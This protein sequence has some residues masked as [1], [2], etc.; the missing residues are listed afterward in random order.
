[1]AFLDIQ[2]PEIDGLEAA[3]RVGAGTALV[4]VTAY[5]EHAVTAFE[6]DAVDYVLKPVTGARLYDTVARVQRRLER[7]AS[8]ATAARDAAPATTAAADPAPDLQAGSNAPAGPLRWITVNDG[9]ELR[10]L[11]TDEIIYFEADNKTLRVVTAGGAF[12]V[13]RA[14]R[15]VAAELDPSQFWQVHRGFI[16]NSAHLAGLT[17]DFRGKLRVRLRQRPETVPVSDS[18]AERLR[19]L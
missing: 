6:R 7:H 8:A 11:T 17:R 9:D 2:M 13:R 4:F 3:R 15:E 18:F 12:A 19:D 1:V 10:L 5:A 16:V 14:L